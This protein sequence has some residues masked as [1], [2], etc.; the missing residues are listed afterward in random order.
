ML[1][2]KIT[3]KG[4]AG[5]LKSL[6]KELHGPPMVALMLHGQCLVPMSFQYYCITIMYKGI[7]S[8]I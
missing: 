4:G 5:G 1:M 6:W 8:Q 2:M 3:V 7:G